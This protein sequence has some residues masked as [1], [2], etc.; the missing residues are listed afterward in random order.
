[1]NAYEGTAGTRAF[2]ETGVLALDLVNTW[3]EYLEEPERLPDPTS[4]RRFLSEH[5]LAWK[6]KIQD[7]EACRA[8]R[9]ELRAIVAAEAEAELVGRL[10]G[11]AAGV[12]AV[13]T[14][15]GS[16]TGSWR[17]SLRPLRGAS[18][19]GRLAVRA[20][21]ELT[22]LLEDHGAD[23]IRTCGAAPC[24]DAFV[25]TSRNGTRRYCSRRCANRVNAAAHR[26]RAATGSA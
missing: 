25:D 24:A 3:D 16:S 18:I 8:L 26:A 21:A 15:A 13:P 10:E 14:I 23:R 6:P 9:A 19:A 7:L 2:F 5:D 17:L 11:F 20:V 12:E 22:S 4:L 1:M